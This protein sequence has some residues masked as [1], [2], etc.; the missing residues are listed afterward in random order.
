MTRS[1]RYKSTEVRDLPTY[2]GLSE[3]DTFLN[4]FE[5]EVLEKQRFHALDWVLRA[6]P[7]RWWNMPK[8]SYDDWHECMGMMGLRFGKPRVRLADKYNGKDDSHTL[9]A[10][11][12]QVYGEKSQP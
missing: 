4:K 6:T 3:L 8:G 2:D 11:W 5:R 12:T 1:L 7:V 9:L 10:K